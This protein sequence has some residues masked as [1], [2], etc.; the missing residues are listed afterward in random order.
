MILLPIVTRE[1]RVASRRA[2]TYWTRFT[3]GLL[4]IV[5]GS[6]AWAM[7]FRESPRSTGIA[8]FV[9]LS[10]IAYIYS[11]IAGAISTAD[12]VSEEKREG[13]LGLLFLTDL[14]SYDIVLGKLAASSVTA[15]YGLLAIFPVMGIPLLLGGVA[16]SEF[17]R[18]VLVCV[19]NLFLSLALGMICSTICKDERKSI[20]LTLLII[21]LLTGGLPGIVG[22]I[23]SEVRPGNPLYKLFHD[24]VYMLLAPSPGFACFVAFDATFKNV[25]GTAHAHWF[26][27]SLA[28][29]HALGWFALILTTIILPRVWHDKAATPQAVCRQE[30]WRLWTHGPASARDAFRRRLLDINPFYWLASRDRSKTVLVWLWVG[31]AA[32]LWISGLLKEKNNWMDEATYIWTALLAH[33]FF[34][35]WLAME[36]SRRLGADRR[37]GALELL[38]STPLSVNEIL[39]GQWLA[40]VRQFGAAVALVCAID[41]LFL[42]LGLKQMGGDRGTW[43]GVWIAGIGV[44]VL[45]LITLALLAMWLSLR[46]RKSSQAG[47]T[48]IVRVC[49]VPWF[50]FGAFSAFV[51]ILEG[52][53]NLPF[54]NWSGSAFLIAWVLLS[55]LNDVLLSLWSLRNLRENFRLIATQRLESRAAFWGRLLGGKFSKKAGNA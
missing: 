9:S 49:I 27:N 48:A 20:G 24:Q 38:L 11:L 4:A 32:L 17:W 35:C 34:K 21:L 2:A 1:L 54:S 46:N 5:V 45:D 33:T 8:L 6:F 40:L 43:I 26:Y 51:A 28:I 22:W 16:P 52:V 50:A 10:V 47:L 53:K 7:L 25:L 12:C 18:V 29:T 13:T 41:F 55:V 37:S 42:G 14:K 31:A 19:N 44:F 15:I 36:A 39:R 30:K 23:A 3:F